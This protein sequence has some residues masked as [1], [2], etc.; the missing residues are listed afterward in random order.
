MKDIN[1]QI[2][3]D[4]RIGLLGVN[5]EDGSYLIQIPRGARSETMKDLKVLLT[6]NPGDNLV[7]IF[8]ESVGKKIKLPFGVKVDAELKSKIESLLTS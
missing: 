1:I 7:E 6:G 8:V 3:P 2:N 4:D 5:G